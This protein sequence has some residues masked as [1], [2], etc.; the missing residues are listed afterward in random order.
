MKL[1]KLAIIGYGAIAQQL[2]QQLQQTKQSYQ[3]AVLLRGNS[4]RR[5]Q[6]PDSV[7]LL[8]SIDDLLAWQPELVVEAAGQQAVAA[9]L[10]SC[11]QAGH[12]VLITSI[13][14]LADSALHQQLLDDARQGGGRIRLL[15][16]AIGALDYLRAAS[17]LPGTQVH[18]ESRKPLSAWQAELA[19]L[20]YDSSTL[21]KPLTLFSGSADQAAQRYPQNLN[22]AAALA[23]A[24]VGM[25]HTQVQVI[26]DPSAQQNQHILHISGPA[27]ELHAHISNTPSPDNPKTSLL[28]AYSL[29]DAVERHFEVIGFA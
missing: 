25:Q 2:V 1:P 14:A 15:S 5:A 24:G 21:E 29:L 8:T 28:V 3:C 4:P 10:P 13:G 23:L 12:T 7:Q 18:Y 6:V 22:V 27:G 17:R 11:L 20:G 26:A 16:G 19:Q 9:Y